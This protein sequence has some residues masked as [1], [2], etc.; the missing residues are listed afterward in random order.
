VVKAILHDVDAHVGNV[1]QGDD[2][3]IV[4]MAINEGRAKRRTSTLPG[5]PVPEQRV[6]TQTPPLGSQSMADED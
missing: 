6:G 3:T 4:A 2:M 1:A 5:V